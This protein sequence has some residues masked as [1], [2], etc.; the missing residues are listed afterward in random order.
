[1]PAPCSRRRSLRSEVAYSG[2]FDII[3]VWH[4]EH[5]KC[6]SVTASLQH[7]GR[8]PKG[9]CNILPRNHD[10]KTADPACVPRQG[11]CAGGSARHGVSTADQDPELREDALQKAGSERGYR[12]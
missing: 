5:W 11:G 4:L 6:G 1:M 10:L 12:G 2:H 9:C 8:Y 3:C 7:C